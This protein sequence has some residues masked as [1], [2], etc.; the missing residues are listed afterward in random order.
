MVY[1]MK[2]KFL[3]LFFL[4]AVLTGCSG[5]K[6]K[7]LYLGVDP[8]FYPL[9]LGLLEKNTYGY[10][11]DLLLEIAEESNMKFFLVS[12]NWDNLFDGLYQNKYKAVFSS[13]Y[14][15]G[16]EENLYNYSKV[17]LETGPVLI[18]P[19]ESNLSIEQMNGMLIGCLSGEGASLLLEKYP[20]IIVKIYESIPEVLDSV[21]NDY[22]NG[23][24]LET[25]MARSYVNNIYSGKLK[26]ASSL[27]NEGIRLISQKKDKDA[28]KSFN[29]AFKKLQKKGKIARL[30]KRW[31][32]T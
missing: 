2:A 15:Y 10:V 8:S 29:Q 31:G 4:I 11:Q 32:L 22:L 5:K 24:V 30:Q 6:E 26:I 16:F 1:G 21:L 12:A 19:S 17:I 20:N 25:A 18:L 14:P 27:T 23:A 3:I 13:R 28:L 9:G 7:S